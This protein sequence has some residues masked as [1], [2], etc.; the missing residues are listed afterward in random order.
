[1]KTL[2]PATISLDHVEVS[3]NEPGG[4]R[5]RIIPD[6]SLR[7]HSDEHVGLMG[8][9][10]SG[11][12]TLIR[13][14][15]GLDRPTNGSIKIFP[16]SVRKTFVLQRPEDHFVRSTVGAQI[17]SYSPVPLDPPAVH[18]I[19]EEVGL[20]SKLGL[21][22]PL[23][24]S[25]GQQRLLSI[26]CALATRASFVI[27]DEL[28]SGL[29]ADARESIRKTLRHLK[30]SDQAGWIISSHHPDDLMGLVDRLWILQEGS[31]LFDGDFSSGPISALS[32]CFSST[33]TSIYFRLRKLEEAGN[34]LPPEIYTSTDPVQIIQS[35]IK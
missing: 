3:I 19:M 7:F 27:L 31:L 23:E 30:N 16:A 2:L 6:L 22:N 17:N 12:T 4:G 34:S 1:M 32:T 26:A 29:D 21:C 11:K 18:K 33:E 35:L 9:N 24:L 15:M 8:R 10:G 5:R 20:P 14:L 25:L 13:L 28:M